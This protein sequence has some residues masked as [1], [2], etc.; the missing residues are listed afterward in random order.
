MQLNIN[1]DC[2]SSISLCSVQL[3]IYFPSI[4]GTTVSQGTNPVNITFPV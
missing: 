2:P 1:Y 3:F 4:L